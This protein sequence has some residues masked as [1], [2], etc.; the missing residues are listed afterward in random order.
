MSSPDTTL[1]PVRCHITTN[2]QDGKA[3]FHPSTTAPSS[4]LDPNN[5]YAYIYSAKD[6][7]NLSDNKDLDAHLVVATT[8]P[9]PLFPDCGGSVFTVV[10]LKPNPTGAM[11]L[12]HRTQTMDYAI[13]ISGA[14]ELSLDSG[15]KRIVGGGEVVVQRAT[16]HGWRNLSK[17]ETARVA[18]V[19]LAAEKVIV[20]GKELEQDLSGGEK[21]M[22][23]QT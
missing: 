16:M 7:I 4:P 3:S 17:T 15:E 2:T 18:F 21:M 20:G 23:E 8:S 6:P 13:V 19:I 11:G 5:G 1:T 12:M 10:D 9:L 22:E 14:V